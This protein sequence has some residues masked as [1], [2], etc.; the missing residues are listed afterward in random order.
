MLIQGNHKHDGTKSV[1]YLIGDERGPEKQMY[2]V[3]NLSGALTKEGLD[4][5][6]RAY[7]LRLGGSFG[8]AFT[9][10]E[11]LEL[12]AA[13]LAIKAEY[14]AAN[15]YLNELGEQNGTD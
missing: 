6:R 13:F 15:K 12:F 1:S 11:M 4:P 8:A 3:R 14:V 10:N 7:Y 9:E 2:L 5:N